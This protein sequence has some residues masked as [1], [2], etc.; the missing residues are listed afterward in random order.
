MTT[1]YITVGLLGSGKSTWAK[2][3]VKQHPDTKIVC[4]DS[5]REMLN[6]GY[7]YLPELDNIITES[8]FDTAQNLLEGGYSVIIDCGNLQESPDRRGKWKQLEA[9]KR[10][11]V[12]FPHKD[13]EWHIKNRLKKPHWQEVD[14]N[15]VYE[16]EQASIEP[17]NEADYDT[18][19]KIKE[20][21]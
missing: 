3:Y 13:K 15:K 5:F 10:I 19:I 11:V 21:E 7:K 20:E 8:V 1:L 6:G 2:K 4:P 18:V 9:D 12:V 14:W 16:A 17:I